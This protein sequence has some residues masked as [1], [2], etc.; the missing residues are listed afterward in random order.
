MCTSAYGRKLHL[1][2]SLKYL[3][4]RSNHGLHNEAYL[5]KFLFPALLLSF[6][7]VLSPALHADSATVSKQQAISAAQQVNPGRVLSVKLRGSVYQVKTLS[8]G[9]DVRMVSIDAKTGKILGK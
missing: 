5:M 9:G 8:S 1:R 7:L 3:K 6:M 4:Q 2:V